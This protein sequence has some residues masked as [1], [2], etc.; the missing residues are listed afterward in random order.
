MD[1]LTYKR[2]VNVLFDGK[3]LNTNT[4]LPKTEGGQ[5]SEF[6]ANLVYGI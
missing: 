4:R 1:P 3:I 5:T 2:I 6:V